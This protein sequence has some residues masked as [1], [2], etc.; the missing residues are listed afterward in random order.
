MPTPPRSPGR[1]RGARTRL[2][3]KLLNDM[4]ADWEEHGANCLK[5]M[6]AED[7]GGYCKMMVSTLPRELTIETAMTDLDDSQLDDLI[8]QIRQH[9][10]EQRAE[11]VLIE[12]RPVEK[13]R[14]DGNPER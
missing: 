2:G 3:T 8:G 5:I 4:L 10:L 11:P 12:A 1:P 9:L 6:R 13:V 14:I 7:P